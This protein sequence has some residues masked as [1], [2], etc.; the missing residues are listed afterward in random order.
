MATITKEPIGQLHE[1]ISVKIDKA[2][3]FPSFEKSL[4]EYS[5]KASIQGFRP[6]KVPAGLIRKM[7]GASLFVD[8]VLKSVDKEL[9]QYLQNEKIE[10]FAQ[11]LPLDTDLAKLNMNQPE[12]YLFDF[13]IGLKPAFQLADLAKADITAYN[14]DITDAMVTEEVERLQNQHGNM[15]DKNCVEGTANLVNVVF[16]EIDAQGAE[17]SGGVVK[18]NSLLVSCFTEKVQQALNAK[19]SGDHIQIT[20]SEAFE[21]KELGFIISDLG[22]NKDNEA[23]KNKTFR[24]EITKVS[25]L[26]KRELDEAFFTQLFPHEEVKTEAQFLAK[27]KEQI[28]GYWASQSRNQIH[29]QIFHKLVENTAIQFP[30]ALLKKWLT[31]Q[32]GQEGQ[33]KKSEEQLEKEMPNFLN[34]LKWTLISEQIV[35]DQQIQVKPEELRAF[36]QAQLF[37]YMGRMMPNAETRPWMNHYIDKMM[38]DPKYLEDAYTRIQSQKIFEWAEQQVKPVSKTIV[39]DEFTKMLNEHQHTHHH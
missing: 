30:E 16:S 28:F 26:Q 3:Y 35:K 17:V 19:K 22:L 33:P 18:N 5:K 21:D 11:P 1:K 37:T 8:E 12:D 4:K 34:R 38:K 32:N 13:E 25:E 23:D 15:I 6:G 36:A 39:S 2:D 31:A 27:I 9:I 14:I 20:L 24:V 7:Y 10:I 29:D